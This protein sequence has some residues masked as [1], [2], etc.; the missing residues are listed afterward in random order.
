M[1]ALTPVRTLPSTLPYC[2]PRTS[3]SSCLRFSRVRRSRLTIPQRQQKR[4]RE[5]IEATRGNRVRM[6][7]ERRLLSPPHHYLLRF[8]ALVSMARALVSPSP[9]ASVHLF[10]VWFFT[11]LILFSSLTRTMLKGEVAYRFFPETRKEKEKG[12]PLPAS[13]AFFFP[14]GVSDGA[15]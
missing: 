7:G 2:L 14:R 4:G 13:P 3:R 5:K 8:T 1:H 10:L 15:A 11:F 6:W 9:F 12:A